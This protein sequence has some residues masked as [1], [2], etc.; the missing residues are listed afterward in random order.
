MFYL[1]RENCFISEVH[2]ARP[3][4]TKVRGENLIGVIAFEFRR[5][6]QYAEDE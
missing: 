3:P 4:K 6:G 1:E 5:R 2:Q